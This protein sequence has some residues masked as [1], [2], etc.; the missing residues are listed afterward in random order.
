MLFSHWMVL[1]SLSGIIWLWLWGFISGL[2]ILFC[3]SVCIY[4]N[5][6]LFWPHSIVISLKLEIVWPLTLF[7]IFKIVLTFQDLS[8]TVMVVIKRA[9]FAKHMWWSSV[10]SKNCLIF[11][12][13][14][15]SL[16]SLWSH[17]H[18]IILV[19]LSSSLVPWRHSSIWVWLWKCLNCA[20]IWNPAFFTRC[21]ILFWNRCAPIFCG[22]NSFFMC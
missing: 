3:C 7:F 17:Y 1:A 20:L 11:W 8:F 5:T 4:I 14:N 22:A 12:D 6:T 21:A 19:K 16:Q 18:V 9:K 15:H 2:S 10:F 13:T